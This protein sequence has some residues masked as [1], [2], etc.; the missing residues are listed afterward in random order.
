M[1][2]DI[3]SKLLG[4]GIAGIMETSIFHPF[5]TAAK[6]LMSNRNILS[7][8]NIRGIIVQS[9]YNITPYNKLSGLYNGFS[10]SLAHRFSQRMY[11]YG[12]QPI[13]KDIIYDHYKP[14]NKH[15]RVFCDYISGAFIGIGEVIFMPFEVL[16]IKKQTN[17]HTF[18]NRSLI[19][20]LREEEFKNYYRGA[21]ITIM[22]NYI[23]VGNFFMVSSIIREYYYNQSSQWNMA[24]NDYVFIGTISSF[25]SITSSSPLDVI[26]TRIQNKNFGEYTNSYSVVKDIIKN[27]GKNAFYRGVIT[28][29]FTIGPKIVFT[30]SM[31]QYLISYFQKN[32]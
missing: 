12:G 19:K 2:N 25:F 20:I 3:K 26:K 15:N 16:K 27:E 29:L 5:D 23:A 14:K 13:L 1:N 28:K 32:I 11:S 17:H 7:R 6:R 18:G 10:F 4:S 8:N 24:F 22:R 30:Y 9:Q 31:S 21:S